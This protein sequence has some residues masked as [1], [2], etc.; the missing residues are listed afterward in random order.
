MLAKFILIFYFFCFMVI[1]S[2]MTSISKHEYYEWLTAY[3]NNSGVLALR[4]PPEYFSDVGTCKP[5][6]QCTNGLHESRSCG[7]F[8]DRECG[9]GV[10]V[11]MWIE[12]VGWV[13][14]G[15]VPSNS[16]GFSSYVSSSLNVTDLRACPVEKTFNGFD[17]V[18]CFRCLPHELEA[19]GCGTW[20]NRICLGQS[21]VHVVI[22]GAENISTFDVDLLRQRLVSRMRFNYSSFVHSVSV[23]NNHSIVVR[24]KSCLVDSFLNTSTWTCVKCTVCP[25]G[26]FYTKNCSRFSDA[27]CVRCYVCTENEVLVYPCR[28]FSN[29][30]CKGDVVLEIS[31]D[32]ASDVDEFLLNWLLLR[33]NAR[34]FSLT[35]NDTTRVNTCPAF[36]YFDGSRCTNC[37]LCGNGTYLAAACTFTADTLCQ[38]CD[39][40]SVYQ[41][42]ACPCSVTPSC[43]TGR[44]LCYEYST[45]N[46]TLFISAYNA[47]G[48]GFL[49]ALAVEFGAEGYEI[50]A[51]FNQNITVKLWRIRYQIPPG[52]SDFSSHVL[53][54][55]MQGSQNVSQ[56][57]LMQSACS[58]GYYSYEFPS[59]IGYHCVPCQCV[60]NAYA[61]VS[62]P[63]LLYFF[64]DDELCPVPMAWTCD[65]V[66]RYCSFPP[67]PFTTDVT[68]VKLDRAE[69]PEWQETFMQ[70]G[71]PV[72][73]GV[74][75]P[76]G[77]EGEAGFC[78]ECSPGF[79]KNSTGIG[80]C[81]PCKPG[82]FE[83]DNECQACPGLSF[84]TSGSIS[85]FCGPGVVGPPPCIQCTIGK[86]ENTYGV[87]E[88]CPPGSFSSSLGQGACTLCE[89]GTFSRVHGASRCDYCLP[90]TRQHLYGASFCLDCSTGSY[91][92]L[93][94]SKFTSCILC[95]SGSYTSTSGSTI[96]LPCAPG[97]ISRTGSTT[98][99]SCLPG[100][101]SPGGLDT[102]L[103]CPK[104]SFSIG[105]AGQCSACLPGLY[106]NVASTSC[107]RCKAG[108]GPIIGGCQFCPLGSQ[109]VMGVC[110]PCDAG[111]FSFISGST[112]CYSCKLGT[113]S[114]S[115]QSECY[116]C[117]L[118]T[119]GVACRSC[120]WGSVTYTTGSLDCLRCPDGTYPNVG[121]CKN[122]PPNTFSKNFSCEP[123]PSDT[124]SPSGSVRIEECMAKEGYY[125]ERGVS[126]KQCPL[127]H[128]CVLGSM[129]PTPCANYT[130]AD[131][132]SSQCYQPIQRQFWVSWIVLPVWLAT[133]C[134]CGVCLS[135]KRKKIIQLRTKPKILV[136]IEE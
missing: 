59:P 49:P 124:V 11:D 35:A 2:S 19:R 125:A 71:L 65:G 74:D 119:F 120:P 105:A 27:I 12:G 50:L 31:L 113:H 86:F 72:C 42:E 10:R 92:S 103:F 126:A 66:S 108:Q 4:C 89:A 115:G 17:C 78:T 87:C 121:S 128:Y 76:P 21:L 15:L 6:V 8:N 56:R 7:P 34:N 62:T 109:E 32:G 58:M 129:A 55:A 122:C 70:S 80:P 133:C 48:A 45:Q 88:P 47:Y 20:H 130:K 53:R 54:A 93:N 41:Y 101:Y 13:D 104:N 14:V 132:G 23:K 46:L 77:F 69:C 111:K 33:L 81:E 94:G 30:Q 18:P 22:D 106:S 98:C 68:I 26:W 40:C 83:I 73:K 29:A 82:Y 131:V 28:S 107:E 75:C 136:K 118:N 24:P 123:C 99:Q 61:D 16:T 43:P 90:G 60:P 85:C 117:P 36:Q 57:R 84:S 25:S 134:I 95:E 5:C 3:Q 102:C 9:S 116:S 112:T 1:V 39:V 79:V 52:M 51:R 44:R 63:P 97:F 67:E 127:D 96:C 37:T 135:G 91:N 114:I 38:R 64:L 100:T 110:L